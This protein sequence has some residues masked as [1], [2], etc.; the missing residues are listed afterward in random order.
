MCRK[1]VLKL[2]LAIFC[3]LADICTRRDRSERALKK[4]AAGSSRK[5]DKRR[6]QLNNNIIDMR[7]ETGNF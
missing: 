6:P 4:V 1:V 7:L 5:C 2:K 3:Y